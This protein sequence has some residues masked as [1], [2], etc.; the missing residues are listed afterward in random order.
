MQT[1]ELLKHWR[2]KYITFNINLELACDF[3]LMFQKSLYWHKLGRKN[4]FIKLKQ[5]R[6]FGFN[7][8]MILKAN[9]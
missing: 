4:I 1:E 6:I 3:F 9:H 8:W 5:F 7:F 2:T